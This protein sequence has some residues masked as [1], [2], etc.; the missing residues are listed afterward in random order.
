MGELPTFERCTDYWTAAA[1]FGYVAAP[2]GRPLYHQLRAG[3]VAGDVVAARAVAF[4]DSHCR[5]VFEAQRVSLEQGY[6]AL[7]GP[8]GCCTIHWSL[9]ESDGDSG[10]QWIARFVGPDVLY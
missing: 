4:Q 7:F 10:P 9:V 8:S 3:T 2:D 6:R 5:R 1:A